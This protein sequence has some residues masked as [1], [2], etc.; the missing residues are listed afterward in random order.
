MRNGNRRA[1][2]CHTARFPNP[3]GFLAGEIDVD[4]AAIP[5]MQQLDQRAREEI[6]AAITAD[7]KS[8]LEGVTIDD[9]VVI[10]FHANIATAWS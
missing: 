2:G 6:V 7:M 4:T 5:S 1:A 10:P 9:H 8:P 3:D